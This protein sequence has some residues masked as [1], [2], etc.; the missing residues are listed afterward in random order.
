MI[1]SNVLSA[2][3]DIAVTRYPH[4]AVFA[5][6]PDGTWS[7]LA[8]VSKTPTLSFSIKPEDIIGL[9]TRNPL[10]LLHTHPKGNRRPS[11][12][13]SLNQIKWKWPWGILPLAGD[14]EK[15]EWVGEPLYWGDGAPRA[16]LL[17]RE[18]I[19]G[20][21]DCFAL[22]RD[23]YALNGLYVGNMPRIGVP[24]AYPLDHPFAHKM[25]EYWYP[26]LGFKPI[27]RHQLKPGD[28]V[29]TTWDDG[30]RSQP[31]H[32]MI[33]LGANKYLEHHEG[34][35]SEIRSKSPA[36]LSSDALFFRLKRSNAKTHSSWRTEGSFPQAI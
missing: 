28:V 20:V 31:D 21:Q 34:R 10:V 17:G 11:D 27:Q 12:A 2:I 19:F 29:V 33:N 35:L 3:T 32:A 22:C 15:V 14:G 30:P 24:T 13:D 18:Y 16:P 4:E 1:P 7:E 8:N 25:A 23:F 5:V 26:R 36:C 6:W 9:Q